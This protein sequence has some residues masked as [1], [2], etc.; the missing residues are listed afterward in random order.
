MS[1][2][3]DAL[4]YSDLFILFFPDRGEVVEDCSTL[5]IAA[6]HWVTSVNWLWLR[7]TAELHHK[8]ICVNLVTIR[9][10]TLPGPYILCIKGE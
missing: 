10:R 6:H 9:C 5:L 8:N 2:Y 3:R 4:L 1:N 7:Q